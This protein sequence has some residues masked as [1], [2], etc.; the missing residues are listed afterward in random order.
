MILPVFVVLIFRWLR[1]A[2]SIRFKG[3]RRGGHRRR[4]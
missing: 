3:R 1:P 2:K 4:Y